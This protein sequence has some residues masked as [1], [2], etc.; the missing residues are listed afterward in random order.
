MVDFDKNKKKYTIVAIVAI[1]FMGFMG[2]AFSEVFRG[3]LGLTT[4]I[5]T[6]EEKQTEIFIIETRRH[7][8]DAQKG[9]KAGKKQTIIARSASMDVESV[10][11]EY[12][13][14]LEDIK[15]ERPSYK[16]KNDNNIKLSKNVD[17]LMDNA[18]LELEHSIKSSN[19]IDYQKHI[20]MANT[21]IK[22]ANKYFLEISRNNG[23]NDIRPLDD[24][25]ASF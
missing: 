15:T 9:F 16:F 20:D 25:S 17:S 7:W 23:Y 21:Q 4:D 1:L 12:V 8:T 22:M 14:I 18:I 6:K 2:Y 13:T 11:S 10:I 5:S 19:E 24:V 3:M